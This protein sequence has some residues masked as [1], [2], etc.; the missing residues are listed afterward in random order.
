MLEAMATEQQ[1]RVAPTLEKIRDEIKE[2]RSLEFEIA[3][4][5]ERLKITKERV[6]FLKEKTLV[7]MFD[8]AGITSLG[9]EAHGNLPPY[10]IEIKPYV[11]ANIAADW[12]PERRERAYAWFEKNGHGDMLRNTVTVHL[13]K[14]T[15]KAQRALLAFLKKSGIDYSSEY[16][17]PWNTL[18]AFV[19]EQIK[20]KKTPPLEML[21][22]TVGRVA[23]V[24][25][26]KTSG[27]AGN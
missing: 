20:K 21:G 17:I 6:R 4:M 25:K 26:E 11:R 1:E 2:L 15:Q 22:A 13:G 16:G 7:D 14:G 12:E 19:K 3:S 8:G 27:K 18:T 23:I 10:D 9:V 24:I 5:E